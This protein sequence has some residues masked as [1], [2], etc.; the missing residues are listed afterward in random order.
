MART[1]AIFDV[2][3]VMVDGHDVRP[4]MAQLLGIGL[5]EL[6]PLLVTA[7]SDELAVGRLS[8][9][10]FWQRMLD[11]TG[12]G[13]NEDLWGV[14]F[15]PTRRPV[16]YDLVQRLQAAGVRVVAGTNTMDAHFQIHMNAG[17]YDVFNKVY[18]SQIMGVAKPDV[19][20]WEMI[21]DAEG[22]PATEAVFVD[23]MAENTEA[24]GNLGLTT[25]QC[26]DVVHTV[27]EVERLFGL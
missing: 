15:E 4:R 23:D 18:A 7:G 1:L 21:L 27:A 17:D 9:Q 14:T 25:V 13:V 16:M 19:K 5:E 10:R 24:A 12:K 20:F 3:G 26:V 6:K 22:V 2:G 8:A 11:L